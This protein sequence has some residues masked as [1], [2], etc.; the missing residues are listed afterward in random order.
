MKD[1]AVI[2]WLVLMTLAGAFLLSLLTGCATPS[3]PDETGRR[4]GEREKMF[5]WEIRNGCAPT[6]FTGDHVGP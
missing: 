2:F 4:Y 1:R 6:N 3:N 5:E